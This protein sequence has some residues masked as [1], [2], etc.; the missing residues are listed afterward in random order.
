M[1]EK[2]NSPGRGFADIT[3]PTPEEEKKILQQR[4]EEDQRYNEDLVKRARKPEELIIPVLCL[5]EGVT[6]TYQRIY[7]TPSSERVLDG[8]SLV[9][10]T[11]AVSYLEIAVETET[12]V[13][14]L[15]LEGGRR[16][17]KEIL[18]LR[19]LILPKKS[20]SETSREQGELCSL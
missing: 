7:M 16:L 5:V 13:Q 6:G 14:K 18:F 17:R 11:G 4:L 19:M 9:Y 1:V 2:H 10:N 15:N 8:R 20:L 12:P 3:F